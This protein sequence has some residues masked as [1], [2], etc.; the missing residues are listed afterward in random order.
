[1]ASKVRRLRSIP[2]P[3]MPCPGRCWGITCEKL[4]RCSLHWLCK[5]SGTGI[6]RQLAAWITSCQQATLCFCLFMHYPWT[7]VLTLQFPPAKPS[8]AIQSKVTSYEGNKAVC[9]SGDRWNV[10]CSPCTTC[11]IGSCWVPVL[12]CHASLQLVTQVATLL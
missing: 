4:H 8:S 9:S 10:C 12:V 11:P 6:P 2:Q 7:E 5:K 3:W 1:M